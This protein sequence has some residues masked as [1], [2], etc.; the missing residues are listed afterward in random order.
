MK[1]YS[2]N[3]EESKQFILSYVIEDGYIIA[4]LANGE[5]YVVCYTEENEQNILNKMKSQANSAMNREHKIDRQIK[6]SAIWTG[7][8]MFYIIFNACIFAFDTPDI[9]NYIALPCTSVAFLINGS[10]FIINLGK[11]REIKKLK[12]F[13]DNEQV[14]NDHV[15]ENTNVLSRINEKKVEKIQQSPKNKPVFDINTIDNYNLNDLK[16]LKDNIERE[17]AFGF[18]QDHDMDNNI[19]NKT[20]VLKPKNTNYDKQ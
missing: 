13:L 4:K 5:E 11:K 1:D 7:I 2:L 9:W 10:S 15:Q 19:E 17:L 3:N 16:T 6:S 12:Y 20:M 14:L 8:M 18:I